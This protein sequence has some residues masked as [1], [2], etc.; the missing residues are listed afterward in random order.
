MKRN[1][2]IRRLT[3]PTRLFNMEV[4]IMSDLQRYTHKRLAHDPIFAEEFEAGYN[5]FK[6][7]I[8]LREARE[9]MGL[10]QEQ[11]A[12]QIG[13]KRWLITR[14][15]N[16]AEQVSLAVLRQYAQVVGKNLQVGLVSR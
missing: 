7:G 8:L 12:Q 11:V 3:T 14:I 9:Q 15:E 6:I 1:D 4:K 16:D 13:S 2:L 5:N 10:T